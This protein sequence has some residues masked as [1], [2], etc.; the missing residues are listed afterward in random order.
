MS[1]ENKRCL[2]GRGSRKTDQKK[3]FME[4]SPYGL[5]VCHIINVNQLQFAENRAFLLF[6]IG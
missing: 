1:H 6:V 5:T 3:V 2:A 4:H